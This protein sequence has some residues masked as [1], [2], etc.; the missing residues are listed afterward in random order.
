MIK[1][2]GILAAMIAPTAPGAGSE[3]PLRMVAESVSLGI[4]IQ[5]IG[6]ADANCE[7]SFTLEV[8]SDGNHSIH[9]GTVA[10]EPGHPVTLSTV[11]VGVPAGRP[12]RASLKVESRGQQA[13]EQVA[14]SS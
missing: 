14:S 6:S 2:L 5:V 1:L 10:L 11:N 7:A 12:W 9:K 3:Q 4:R 8:S 13:Y